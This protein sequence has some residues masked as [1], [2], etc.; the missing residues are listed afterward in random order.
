MKIEFFALGTTGRA[1]STRAEIAHPLPCRTVTCL[2]L[3]LLS[4]RAVS[5]RQALEFYH[6]MKG[7]LPFGNIFI[8]MIIPLSGT[9]SFDLTRS[10]IL[11]KRL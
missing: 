3:R 9:L 5:S 7:V 11:S 8:W 2:A 1:E 6:L 10:K 4:S